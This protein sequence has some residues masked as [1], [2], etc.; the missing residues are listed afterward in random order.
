MRL[1]ID[2]G[3]TKIEI[4][5]LNERT[6]EALLRERVPTPQGD[7]DGTLRA[8]AGLVRM[9]EQRTGRRG[10]VGIGIPGTISPATG[11]IK[12]ANSVCLIGH[13]LDKDLEAILDRPVRLANDANCFA[14][15][16]ATDGAAAG[17]GVVF[18]AILGTG[19]GGGIV[20]DGRPLVGPNSIAGE[21]G[22]TPLPWPQDAERPGP[23]CYCG[24]DG[25]LE[26]FLSGGGLALDYN[27]ATGQ[28]LTS[29]DI[30]AAAAQGEEAAELALQRYEDRLARALASMMNILDPD[31]I[32]LGGGLSTLERLYV[33]VPKLWGRYV[34]SDTVVT[35][36]VPPMHGD[37]SGV[38]GAAWLWPEPA[39]QDIGMNADA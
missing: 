10:T 18:G 21:W 15:S 20:V 26:T 12:N 1:G 38:R 13:A 5:A 34:F 27:A 35:P 8:I 7:Y 25:C 3:G 28:S 23:R 16:E 4:I 17:A 2:L 6:G 37:S 29:P 19:C 30:C 24:L 33:N 9:A 39:S 36:L 14:L 31:V 32:V 11:L 22:H